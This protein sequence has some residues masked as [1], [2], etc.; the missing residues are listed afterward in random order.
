MAP[1]D[2]P[3][4]VRLAPAQQ[5]HPLL[6]GLVVGERL[7]DDIVVRRA[8][9][10]RATGVEDVLELPGI[11]PALTLKRAGVSGPSGDGVS[12]EVAVLTTG[13]DPSWSG[14]PRSGFVVPLLHRLA[15]RL[16][17]TNSRPASVSVGD[18]LAVRLAEVPVGRMEVEPPAGPTLTAELRHHPGPAAVVDR[19]GT[20]GVYRF[21]AGGRTVALGAVNVDPRESDLTQADRSEVTELLSPLPLTFIDAGARLEDEVLQARYGRELWRAFLYVALA[22]LAV[23]MYLARPRSVDGSACLALT[24]RSAGPRPTLTRWRFKRLLPA[25]SGRDSDG[26][27]ALPRSAIWPS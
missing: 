7:V 25:G 10:V 15:E 19:A 12:G 21:R 5:G 17:R 1:A 2:R 18:D 13:I 24:S 9:N 3:D 6:D 16:S 14:L 11:G 23:E 27:S 26:W 22:L 4:G 20:P 8:F